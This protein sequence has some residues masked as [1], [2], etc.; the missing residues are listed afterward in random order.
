MAMD[1]RRIRPYFSFGEDVPYLMYMDKTA[2]PI[3][4]WF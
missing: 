3:Q 2:F 4:M 1:Y